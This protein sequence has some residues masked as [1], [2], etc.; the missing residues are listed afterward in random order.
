MTRT[1]FVAWQDKLH[2]RQWYPIG[3]L[4][5]DT[6]HS[7]YR[8]RYVRGAYNAQAKAGFGPLLA[9][10]KFEQDYHSSELFPLFLN[11][12]MKNDRSDFKE[13]IHQLDMTPEQAAD[14]LEIFSVT[15]GVRETDNLEVFPKI[16]KNEDGGFKCRFFLHGYRHINPSA[17]ERLKAVKLGDELRVAIE[18]NNPVTTV[19]I[20]LQSGEDY[21]IL[22]WA[23]RYLIPDLMQAMAEGPLEVCAYMVKVN[24]EP[25]PSKQRYLI[26]MRGHLPKDVNPM[27]SD[28]FRPLVN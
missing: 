12:L 15:G 18:S 23:P 1:L 21:Y 28:E 26:E 27:S 4:D 9:F 24:P 25:A 17:Q 22:G 13:Y 16:D 2:T 8:F 19:A 5:A 7:D 20:Q 6:E 11:R 10:P 3:R 14:P